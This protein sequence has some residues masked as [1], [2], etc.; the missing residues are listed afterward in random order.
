VTSLTFSPDGKTLASGSG[1]YDGSSII[2]WDVPTGNPMGQPFSQPT[3]S[4]LTS[5]AFSPDGRILA[6]G[7]CGKLDTVNRTVICVQGQI[8]WW[9]VLT[10]TSASTF[11]PQRI[12]QH[13]MG[14]A[15]LVN[16]VAFRPDGEILASGGCGERANDRC[17][18]GEIILWDVA[19][20]QPIG[21][22]LEG[23]SGLV[24]SVAFSPD[25]TTL[26][27]VSDDHTIILWDVAARQRVGQP[28]RGHSDEVTSVAFSPD[29]KILASG[30]WDETIILW[31]IATRQRI[32]QPLRGPVTDNLNC[33]SCFYNI[34]SV[35]FSPDGKTLAS[36]RWDGT[37]ILWDLETYQVIGEPLA[38]HTDFVH[39][40]AFS[41]DGETLASGSRD[42]SIILW[43]IATQQRTGQPLPDGAI[44]SVAF[45]QDGKTLVSGSFANTL[46]LWDVASHQPIGHPLQGH[47]DIVTS[48]AFSPDG[49]TLA[50]GSEDHTIVLWDLNPET[51]VNESCQ[52]V[53]RNLTR[54]EWVQYFSNEEYR[55][56]CEQWPLEP[57]APLVRGSMP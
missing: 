34:E 11:T 18:R 41:P 23:H 54:A 1:D 37:V 56:T 2:L 32:G 28:L 42:G 55:K 44:T 53:G 35:A 40:V 43:D 38:G 36:G 20:H 15:D 30:G 16:S 39:S 14:Q 3:S 29:G 27:S 8:I 10:M 7:G 50:S 57:E 12:G 48:V 52:R 47:S 5:L 51:W 25:G 22:P 9:D 21:Q 31:D 24:N 13:F 6:S 17:V 45:S 46:I 33:I 19:A 49:K 4:Y 26:A